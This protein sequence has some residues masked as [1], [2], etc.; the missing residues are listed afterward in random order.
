MARGNGIIVSAEPKGRFEEG[1]ISGTPKPG[2]VV[3]IKS[4]DSNG[5]ITWEA[6]GTTAANST[7]SGMAADGNRM[8]IAVLLCAQDHAACPLNQDNATAYADGDRCAVYYPLPG[9]RLNMIYKDESGTGADQDLVKGLTKLIVDDGTGKLVSSA[10]TPESEP[11]LSLE[12]QT[13]VAADVLIE[14][15]FTGF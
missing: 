7:F 1:V 6:A 4:I 14:T 8:P 13:D 5:V 9:D 11:F 2:T 12:T 10:G 15:L 3:E